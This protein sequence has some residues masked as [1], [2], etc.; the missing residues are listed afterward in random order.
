M[1]NGAKANDQYYTSGRFVIIKGSSDISKA[2]KYTMILK[3][4]LEY[5][6]FCYFFFPF[7]LYKLHPDVF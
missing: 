1:I 6:D 7:L 3:K 2:E 5:A 4:N